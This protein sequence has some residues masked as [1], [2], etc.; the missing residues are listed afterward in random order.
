MDP[1]AAPRTAAKHEDDPRAPGSLV[2]AAEQRRT[3]PET[4][5]RLSVQVQERLR[6]SAAPAPHASRQLQLKGEQ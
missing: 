6:P 4:V 1:R 5:E 3:D 2:A